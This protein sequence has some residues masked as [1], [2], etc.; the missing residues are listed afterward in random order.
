MKKE[1]KKKR[2]INWLILLLCFALSYGT[3][4]VGSLFTTPNVN[5]EWYLSIKPF[6]TPPSII[7]PIV[8]NVLFFLIAISLYLALTSVKDKKFQLKIWIVF[9]INFFLNALW[10]L[11]Y[12]GL[13]NPPLA[14]AE[15][16]VLEVSTL[17]IMAVVWKNSKISVWLL[18][19]YSLWLGFAAILTY[20]SAF[21]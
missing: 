1:R 10:S 13:R 14:F 16:I 12:F 2:K 20:L 11:L 8:W 9:G 4:F 7:F 6:I 3:G 5:S 17:A 21:V 18:V 19:P 15:V